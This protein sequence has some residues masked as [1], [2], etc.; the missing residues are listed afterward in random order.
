MGFYI[1][2]T[3]GLSKEFWLIENGRAIGFKPPESHYDPATDSVAVCLVDNGSWTAAAI[4]Y[5]HHEFARFTYDDPE[6]NRT[7]L[8]FMVKRDKLEPFLHGQEIETC[9]R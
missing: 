5:D 7:Q 8:W 4:A 9:Q 1:N 3:N 6:D 2:M